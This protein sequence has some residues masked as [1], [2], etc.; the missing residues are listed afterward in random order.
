MVAK[1]NPY[2]RGSGHQ[3]SFGWCVGDGDATTMTDGLPAYKH[4]GKAQPHLAVNHSAREYERT[5]ATTGKRVHVNRVRSAARTVLGPFDAPHF[6]TGLFDSRAKPLKRGI[7]RGHHGDDRRAKIKSNDAGSHRASDA[8]LALLDQL[9][10]P[11]NHAAYFPA[12][13]TTIFG[14][15]LQS[16]DLPGV[17]GSRSEKDRHAEA[18]PFDGIACKADTGPVR[19]ALD[20]NNLT[21]ALEARTPM[22]A[23]GVHL[24][25]LKSAQRRLLCLVRRQMVGDSAGVLPGDREAVSH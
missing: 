5:D 21:I 18:R 12:D 19:L 1:V 16:L 23:E 6:F 7:R 4:I 9:H 14:P 11:A 17:G 3:F 13:Q 2:A 20:R 24:H 10:R 25:R 8:R 15:M 22:L